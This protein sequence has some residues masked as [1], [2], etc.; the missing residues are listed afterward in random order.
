MQ[1]ISLK[2]LTN[3]LSCALLTLVLVMFVTSNSFADEPVFLPLGT[4]TKQLTPKKPKY[5]RLFAGSTQVD[6]FV[7]ATALPGI[8]SKNLSTACARGNF[9][10]TIKKRYY[11]IVDMPDGTPK[12][13]G[14]ADYTG[15]NLTDPD[16]RKGPN[17]AYLFEDDKTSECK[18]YAAVTE[19]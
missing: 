14:F 1:T 5:P 10:Q 2:T 12:K 15:I 19:W 11:I 16:N 8:L 3:L 4:G 13:F 7:A 9:N 17:Q 6:F 18:V